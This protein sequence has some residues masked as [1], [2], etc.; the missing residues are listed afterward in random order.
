MKRALWLLLIS[1]A[2][3]VSGSGCKKKEKAAKPVKV[4]R[5]IKTAKK[6]YK[7]PVK[8]IKKAKAKR[9]KKVKKA[10]VEEQ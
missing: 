4:E 6:K 5:K 2:L 3:V 8:K 7:K 1:A 9:V 10:A